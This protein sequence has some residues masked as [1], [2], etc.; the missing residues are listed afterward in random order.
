LPNQEFFFFFLFF[1]FISCSFFFVSHVLNGKK[2]KVRIRNG[3]SQREEKLDEN[4]DSVLP[5]IYTL[6]HTC[7]V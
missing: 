7:I 6:F 3:S 5:L 1:P 2:I 4:S